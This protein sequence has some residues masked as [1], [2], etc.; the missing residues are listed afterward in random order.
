MLISQATNQSDIYSSIGGEG[1]SLLFMSQSGKSLTNPHRQMVLVDFVAQD[2]QSEHSHHSESASSQHQ[3]QQQQSLGGQP[4]RTTSR[5]SNL[6]SVGRTRKVST[7]SLPASLLNMA[8]VS[9]HFD[10]K[11]KQVPVICKFGRKRACVF[12]FFC[13]SFTSRITAHCSY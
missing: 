2:M 7:S 10:R 6:S 9:L 1:R 12:P 8:D 3:Q 11:G 4:T 13:F 5:V